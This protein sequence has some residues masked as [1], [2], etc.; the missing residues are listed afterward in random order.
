MVALRAAWAA[1]IDGW[2]RVARAPWLLLALAAALVL[3]IASGG[4]GGPAMQVDAAPY[5]SAAL[6]KLSGLYSVAFG[7]SLYAA[8]GTSLGP[9]ISPQ[10]TLWVAVACL[11]LAG[12]AIDRYA[13]QRP[14]DARTFWGISGELAFRL[15]RLAA[16]IGLILSAVLWL[17]SKGFESL[18]SGARLSSWVLS[19]QL[20]LMI[21]L[22]LAG[23]AIH[24]CARV[25]LVVERRRS[26]LFAIVA[27]GRF[28]RRQ[29]AAISALHLLNILTLAT[30]WEVAA[31][32]DGRGF[33]A[34]SLSGVALLTAALAGL[35]AVTSLFQASLAHAGYVAPPRLVWPDSP[36]IE[37]L[38]ERRDF[39]P[40]V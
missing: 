23:A 5:R 29:S 11:I 19:V 35:A 24:D 13:R 30:I 10:L 7:G 16:A 32:L 3:T 26:A 1:Y 31:R 22:T 9:S 25:R 14:L 12:A 18:P 2:A 6:A 17:L 27:G 20:L 38:G 8:A 28:A 4:P 33:V 39:P 36:A 21:G 34:A 37:T 15:V 40:V